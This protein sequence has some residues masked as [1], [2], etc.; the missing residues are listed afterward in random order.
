MYVFYKSIG[1]WRL[2]LIS[3]PFCLSYCKDRLLHFAVI[4]NWSIL[5]VLLMITTM[6]SRLK[7]CISND[8]R[9]VGSIATFGGTCMI[10]YDIL[11]LVIRVCV[12]RTK[13]HGGWCFSTYQQIDCLINNFWGHSN[14]NIRALMTVCACAYGEW[15]GEGDP[16]TGE[17]PSQRGPVMRKTFPCNVAIMLPQ[18]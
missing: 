4:K 7:P 18:G 2:F 16:V 5:R 9:H 3:L 12:I 17:F 10:D 15:W 13:S 14:E 8:T 6:T 11:S 1:Y